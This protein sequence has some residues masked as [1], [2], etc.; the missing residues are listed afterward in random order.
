ML[1]HLGLGTAVAAVTVGGKRGSA[2]HCQLPTFEERQRP[3]ADV[4]EKRK[5]GADTIINIDEVTA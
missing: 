5:A 4:L 3:L 2:S 1:R